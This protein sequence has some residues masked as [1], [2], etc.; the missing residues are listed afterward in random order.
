MK[1]TTSRHGRRLGVALAASLLALTAG[2]VQSQRGDYERHLST[3]VR[4][5]TASPEVALGVRDDEN[6]D[7]EER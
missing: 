1:A 7:D 4:P 2:C 6:V 3:I 5:R